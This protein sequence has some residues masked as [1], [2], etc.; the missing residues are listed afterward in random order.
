[1]QPAGTLELPECLGSC[2]GELAVLVRWDRQAGGAQTTLYIS[3]SVAA[4]EWRG[5]ALDQ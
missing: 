2:F 5:K 4:T 3:Y 1:M